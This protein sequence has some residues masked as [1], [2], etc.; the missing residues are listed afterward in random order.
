MENLQVLITG[1][2][3]KEFQSQQTGQERETEIQHMQKQLA[4]LEADRY[5]CACALG[6]L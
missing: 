2:R 6:V 4:R 3:R 1:E 5:V